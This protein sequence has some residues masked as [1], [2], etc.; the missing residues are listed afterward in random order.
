MSFWWIES[1]YGL[2]YKFLCKAKPKPALEREQSH[3]QP[4]GGRIEW[5]I[6]RDSPSIIGAPH[7]AQEL[8]GHDIQLTYIGLV[9]ANSSDFMI[10][11]SYHM[12]VWDYQIFKYNKKSYYDTKIEYK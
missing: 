12:L 2:V 7:V 11:A 4:G 10:N 3:G 1:I 6:S 5:R 9:I 8:W